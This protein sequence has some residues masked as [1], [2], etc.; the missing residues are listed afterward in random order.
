MLR[1][2]NVCISLFVSIL[3]TNVWLFRFNKETPY[4]GGNAKNMIEEFAAYGLDLNTM[5]LVGSLKIIAS[6]GLIIGLLKTKISV[7]SSLLMAILMTGAIY[8]HFKI[9]DPAI[10]YFPSALMLTCSVFIYF[11]SK[12]ILKTN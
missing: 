7:Y 12:K 8:F 4:R 1:I 2:L 11:S 5:Y 10:K 6:L 3:V 9:S